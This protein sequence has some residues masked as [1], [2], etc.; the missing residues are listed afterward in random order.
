MQDIHGTN[1]IATAPTKAA[2]TLRNGEKG[3]SGVL[4]NRMRGAA[5]PV[6]GAERHP[7]EGVL[8]YGGQGGGD[9]MVSLGTLSRMEP[10]VSDLLIR[11]P[12]FGKDCWQIIHDEKNSAKAFKR[13]QAGTEIFMDRKTGELLWG[14]EA[15]TAL[16]ATRKTSRSLPDPQIPEGGRSA[17]PP[18]RKGLADGRVKGQ[19]AGAA[20][21]KP[22]AGQALPALEK[23]LAGEKGSVAGE[24][25]PGAG[26]F[27]ERLVSAVQPFMGKA[28]DEIDCYGLVVRGL[29]EMGVRYRGE[30]G[31][32]RKLMAMAEMKGLPKNAYINGEGLIKASGT[33]LYAKTFHRVG[34]TEKA[35]E[36]VMQEM[37]PLLEKGLLLSFSTRRRGHTGIVSRQ[38]DGWTYINSGKIDHSIHGGATPGRGVGEERLTEEIQ[39]WFKLS[40]KT[41]DALEISLGRFNENTLTSFRNGGRKGRTSA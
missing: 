32:S 37:A 33:D 23:A 25:S 31:L 19:G 21:E 11:N 16:A 13:M 2:S 6:T 15:A 3:F 24:I 7:V 34:D 29:G 14:K 36:G 5:G 28:Y 8:K 17:N 10:T 27:S 18:E 30:G 40:K 39:N 12:A 20:F 26:S 35:A 38:E 4:E 41:G 1:Q 9:R 22:P